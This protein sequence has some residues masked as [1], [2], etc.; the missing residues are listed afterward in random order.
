ML[1]FCSIHP[2]S[3]AVSPLHHVAPL[4]A[5]RALKMLQRALTP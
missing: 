4:A 1:S 2:L 3:V 5:E